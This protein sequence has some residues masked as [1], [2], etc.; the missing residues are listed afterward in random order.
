MNHAIRGSG[1]R[2][3]IGAIAGVLSLGAVGAFAWSKLLPHGRLDGVQSYAVYYGN[4]L[5]YSAH[6]GD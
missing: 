2:V 3:W 5:E 6:L 1:A 4:K